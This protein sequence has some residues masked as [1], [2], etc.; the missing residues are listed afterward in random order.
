MATLTS[1]EEVDFWR[2]HRKY[3]EHLFRKAYRFCSGHEADA[4]D[5]VQQAFLKALGHWSNTLSALTDRQRVAWLTR[6]II[7]EGLQ[8]WRSRGR[9]VLEELDDVEA[10]QDKVEHGEPDLEKR[11][12]LSAQLRA[13]CVAI[14]HLPG[15]QREVLELHAIAGYE[16][17]EVAHMLGI[18]EETIRVHLHGGRRKLPALL[19]QVQ[20]GEL[21]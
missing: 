3:A 6:T 10:V 13:T 14:T 18:S 20:R 2:F 5:L 9:V 15:R 16:I 8:L 12:F 21:T 1:E 11:V 17:S 7:N 19:G 4:R